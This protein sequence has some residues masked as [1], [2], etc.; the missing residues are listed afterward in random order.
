[1]R[2]LRQGPRRTRLPDRR[3]KDCEEGHEG[4]GEEEGWAMSGTLI[5]GLRRAMG[6]RCEHTA[7]GHERTAKV[8]DTFVS[9]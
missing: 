3:A 4:S 7:C 6:F 9:A 5:W 8:D 1:M 2:Q